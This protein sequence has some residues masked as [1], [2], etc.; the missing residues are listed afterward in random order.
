M[1]RVPPT[2]QELH[3]GG[4]PDA[5]MRCSK[6]GACSA[7]ATKHYCPFMSDREKWRMRPG[8][9]D[10]A[11]ATA[12]TQLSVRHDGCWLGCR[13]TGGTCFGGTVVQ[14]QPEEV[15]VQQQREANAER[16]QIRGWGLEVRVLVEVAEWTAGDWLTLLGVDDAPTLEAV[17]VRLSELGSAV[18]GLDTMGVLVD[19]RGN[20][21]P[22]IDS[23]GMGGGKM[24][25]DLG[26]LGS[27][28]VRKV[29]DR[30][31]QATALDADPGLSRSI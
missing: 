4:E 17:Q 16:G 28:C 12:T 31:V 27:F 5:M 9:V 2:R 15:T 23:Y 8:R 30:W 3:G 29:L 18:Q 13:H 11:E 24:V 20:G 1:P 6:C 22:W 26:V 10:R 14:V 7:A 25:K 21:Q 19:G